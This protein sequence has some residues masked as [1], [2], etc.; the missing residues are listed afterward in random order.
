MSINPVHLGRRSSSMGVI[1]DSHLP[2]L[3]G[4]DDDVLSTGVVMYHLK[5]GKTQ[6]GNEDGGKDLDICE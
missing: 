1:V 5:E 2:H 4:I 6:V 3:I